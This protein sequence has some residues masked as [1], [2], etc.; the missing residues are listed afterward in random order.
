MVETPICDDG[1]ALDDPVAAEAAAKPPR[2]DGWPSAQQVRQLSRELRRSSIATP[3][4]SSPF[5]PIGRRLDPPQHLASELPLTTAPVVAPAISHVATSGALKPRRSRAG[6]IFAWLVVAA[7]FVVLAGGLSLIAW[8]L[9]NERF[10]Y[11]NLAIGLT[12]GGQGTLIFGLVLVV[13]Q[14]WRNSRYA[15]GK[16]HEVHARLGQVQQTADVLATMRSGGAP[17][18]YTDLV[19]GAS[20]QVLLANLK[21][22]LDQLAARVGN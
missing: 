18:F 3:T 8:S 2:F 13:M 4:A 19:R 7:G 6:Q 5:P 22:Q 9:I 11:W 16:L 21:G 12:L 17:A 14:L 15:T 10:V 20:P 1:I